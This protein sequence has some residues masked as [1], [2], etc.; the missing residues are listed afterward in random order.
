MIHILLFSYKRLFL[1]CVGSGQQEILLIL[2]VF[3]F[4]LSFGSQGV[5][6]EEK[7]CKMDTA[8]VFGANTPTVSCHFSRKFGALGHL[9]NFLTEFSTRQQFNDTII[10]VPYFDFFS[11]VRVLHLPFEGVCLSGEEPLCDGQRQFLRWMK[12]KTWE[13]KSNAWQVLIAPSFLSDPYAH[14]SF[15]H[16]SKT[17]EVLG[18]T[19]NPTWDQTLIFEDI[20]IYGDPQTIARNPPDVVLELYDSDQ[21]VSWEKECSQWIDFWLSR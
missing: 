5:D 6:V 3:L 14:V 20:E 11:P 1:P 7:P 16:V 19:L 17:T 15:L 18:T 21:V 12:S 9:S 13:I 2:H 8:K 4:V 10:N